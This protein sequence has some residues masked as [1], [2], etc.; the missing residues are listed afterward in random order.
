[1]M[2]AN[3]LLVA[4]GLLD[5]AAALLHIGCIL[6][7][8]AWYRF[9]GAGERMARMAEAGALTPTLVTLGIAAV[10]SGW[11]AYCFAGAGVLPRL[12][13]MRAALVAIAGVYLVRA[14]ALPWMLRSM[15]ER[16]PGFLV[17][18]SAVVLVLSLIHI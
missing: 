4:A 13:L 17:W 5:I 14:A 8:P 16:D 15:H 9:F 2:A 3:R 10:L 1:M 11:A 12:P 6:G 18:S 7:G